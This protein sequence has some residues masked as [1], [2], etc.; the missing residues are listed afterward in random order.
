MENYE[1]E[2][3]ERFGKIFTLKNKHVIAGVS[4]YGARWISMQVPDRSGNIID[5]VN[6]FNDLQKYE[7]SSTA[8]YGATIGRYANRIANGKFALDGSVYILDANNDMNHLHGG[9]KGLHVVIW[10]VIE[11]TNNTITFKYT[12]ADGEEGYPGKVD[13]TVQYTLTELN[14]LKINFSARTDKT[15]I[16]NL[17]NHSYFNLNGGGTINNHR[18]FINA[19]YYTPINKVL[20]PI[21][22]IETVK[23]TP[24]DFTV[25]T[26]IGLRINDNDQQLKN[27]HGYDHNFVLNKNAEGLAMAAI[28]EGDISKIKMEVFTTE[29]GVQLYTG[30]FMTGENILNNGSI[31]DY[32]TA[33][34]LETQHFPDSPNNLSFPSVVLLPEQEYTSCTIFK[35]STIE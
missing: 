22:K 34:C 8:Y 9:N 25:L 2:K 17:T 10:D 20:I 11:N 32:R 13:I 7:S 26:E 28:A 29:P 15:T 5:V 3:N 12:S 27:G 24:F 30:N 31:D 19:D 18:L 33:F 1:E 6:G 23:N 35:F 14:E 16:I 21:G 4:N